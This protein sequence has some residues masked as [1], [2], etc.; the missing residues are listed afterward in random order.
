MTRADWLTVFQ[1]AAIAIQVSNNGVT[2]LIRGN[3]Y[4][5]AH[6]NLLL[7]FSISSLVLSGIAAGITY[8]VHGMALATNTSVLEKGVNQDA[9]VPGKET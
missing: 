4:L 2:H 7:E 3:A 5:E 6:P 1:A 9:K 8:V